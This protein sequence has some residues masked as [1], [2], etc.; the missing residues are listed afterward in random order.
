MNKVITNAFT[1]DFREHFIRAHVELMSYRKQAEVSHWLF[2]N[3][4]I[5]LAEETVRRV[6]NSKD[7]TEAFVDSFPLPFH[8][9]LRIY[10]T[11]LITYK[12]N[13]FHASPWLVERFAKDRTIFDI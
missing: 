12:V 1:R 2:D 4:R 7:F 9:W 8:R 3:T 6:S 13:G 10:L 11:I 5:G